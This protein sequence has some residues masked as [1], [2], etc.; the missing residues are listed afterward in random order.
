MKIEKSRIFIGDVYKSLS[1]YSA[2]NDIDDLNNFGRIKVA[3][4][5]MLVKFGKSGYVPVKNIKTPIHFYL[6]E[7]KVCPDGMLKYCPAFLLENNDMLS[8]Y[9]V[10]NVRPAFDPE[11]KEEKIDYSALKKFS[12]TLEH[13][14][15]KSYE[16]I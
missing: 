3:Q 4:K 14:N 10:E 16:K 7:K 12:K 8:Q 1:K 9:F 15:K 5:V 2:D 6:L 13:Q 11:K